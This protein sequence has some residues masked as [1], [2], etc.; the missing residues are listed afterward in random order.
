MVTWIVIG[1]LFL[2]CYCPPSKTRK[3]KGD[4]ILSTNSSFAEVDER[5]VKISSVAG[6]VSDS[7]FESSYEVL[8]VTGVNGTARVIS[9]NVSRES[10]PLLKRRESVSLIESC[11]TSAAAD[12]VKASNRA[13]TSFCVLVCLLTAQ[14]YKHFLWT[15]RMLLWEEIVV[16]LYVIFI[17]LYSE[18]AV[19][20]N[21][22]TLSCIQW[23]FVFM[24]AC[25]SLLLLWLKHI[26]TLMSFILAYIS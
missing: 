24:C 11:S 18:I 23:T 15:C 26:S 12:D 13:G 16:L 2:L 19:E 1:F 9:Y 20:V 5:E 10:T 6:V 22:Y 3:F 21:Y 17:M 25:R 7:D 14:I 4:S 8:E